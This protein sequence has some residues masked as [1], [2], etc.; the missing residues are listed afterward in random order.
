M[1]E[2]AAQRQV[3]AV[4][5][6]AKYKQENSQLRQEILTLRSSFPEGSNASLLPTRVVPGSPGS[7]PTLAEAITKISELEKSAARFEEENVVLSGK[8]NEAQAELKAAQEILEMVEK[9]LENVRSEKERIEA[10]AEVGREKAVIE[11]E[12]AGKKANKDLL[13]EG[14]LSIRYPQNLN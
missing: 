3:T 10:E 11:A 7:Q 1:T 5:T 13:V 14:A 6:L 2:V 8:A 4:N 12:A 9:E